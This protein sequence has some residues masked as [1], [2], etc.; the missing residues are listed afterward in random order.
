VVRRSASD[1]SQAQKHA[2]HQAQV[3]LCKAMA[4]AEAALTER[5][6]LKVRN[7]T[8][9]GAAVQQAKVVLPQ[10]QTTVRRATVQRARHL[11]G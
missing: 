11:G 7:N 5:W 4:Q 1:G 10:R 6:Q 2:D 8:A 3:R 9:P